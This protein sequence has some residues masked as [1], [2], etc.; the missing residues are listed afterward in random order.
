MKKR[1]LNALNLSLLLVIGIIIYL[2][3]ILVINSVHDYKPQTNTIDITG[4]HGE[5]GI[6]DQTIFSM[7]SWNIGYAGLGSKSD[8]FY[9]GG[10]MVKPARSDYDSY[11]ERI[12]SRIQT[13]DSLD[14]IL[15]Q[16]VD[17]ASTRSFHINQYANISEH[18]YTHC[19]V[20]V[21]NY[22]VLYVPMPLFNPMA[23]VISGLSFFSRY[24][25]SMAS[26]VVFP[27]NYAWPKKLFMPDRCF[28]LAK[29]DCSSGKKLHIINTHNSAFDDGTLCYSQ[30]KL[31]YEYMQE[32][33]RKGDYIIAGGDWNMN[34][35]GYANIH[36]ISKDSAFALP[37]L[38]SIRGPDSTWTIAF[39]PRYPTNRDV[40]TPYIPGLTP[41]TIIDYYICSPNINVLEV[42][43]L[44]NGF[45]NSDHQPVYLRFELN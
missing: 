9:D 35:A 11:W 31:L 6:A 42:K 27:E 23:R 2:A 44:Y 22:D 20:Y 26:Q 37:D 10:K 36:F 29:F 17:T 16:E 30:L 3:G 33:Y 38:S 25:F 34:P 43:T 15:L 28:I 45:K 4:I 1:F 32:A 12:L 13:L 8:F 7:L 39:D 40:S 41:T 14:F 19:G 21:K 5:P 18:L 24:T